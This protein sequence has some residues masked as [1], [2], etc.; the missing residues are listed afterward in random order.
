MTGWVGNIEE[1]TT[2]NTYFRKVLFT[3][4][5]M[6]LVVMTLQPGE[7]I[8][9]E[10]HDHLDQFIRVES[11]R[12]T[13]TLGPSKDEVADTHHVEDDWAVVIPGGTW[14]NVINEG[15][16]ELKLYTIYTPPQHA[17]GT[18]HETKADADAAEAEHGH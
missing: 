1:A 15:D 3:A 18:V 4:E 9:L 17:D 12:A 8:G 5:H 6:Q 11:G 7:E 14:H 16:Q 13:V 10:M 2:G